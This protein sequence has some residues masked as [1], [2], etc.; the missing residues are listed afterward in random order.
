MKTITQT[1]NLYT[2]EELS[3]KAKRKALEKWCQS[4]DY[5]YYEDNK[6]TLDEFVKHFDFID[7][8]NWEYGGYNRYAEC[9]ID[10]P[11]EYDIYLEDLAGISLYTFIQNY[12]EKFK[13]Y[14]TYALNGENIYIAKKKYQ[15]KI[16]WSYENDCQLTGY[17]LDC[18]IMQPIFDYLEN[19]P[20]HQNKTLGELMNE[21]LT[22]WVV[23]CDS[24]HDYYYSMEC[25]QEYATDND[26][27]FYEDGRIYGE[28]TE[29]V[30]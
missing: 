21:C 13:V 15:S 6:Y 12:M 8:T 27:Y 11:Y 5:P 2:F 26:I 10:T 14:K 28:L 1:I 16:A 3:E 30:A 29:E 22:H 17:C 19:F 18:E 7:S 25:L 23:A 9:T 24:D 4:D 20:K